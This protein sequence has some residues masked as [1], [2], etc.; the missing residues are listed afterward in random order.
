MTWEILLG[1]LGSL[2]GN[3]NAGSGNEIVGGGKLYKPNALR[4]LGLGKQILKTFW[5]CGNITRMNELIDFAGFFYT[6]IYC[7]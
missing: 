4:R 2:Q 3:E 5:G 6:S 7:M 1:G